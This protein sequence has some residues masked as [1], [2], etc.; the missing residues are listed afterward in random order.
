M[1]QHKQHEVVRRGS[2]KLTEWVKRTALPEDVSQEIC[3]PVT[4]TINGVPKVWSFDLGLTAEQRTKYVDALKR[5]PIGKGK[6]TLGLK[7]ASRV[8]GYRPRLILRNDYCSPAS[9][10]KDDPKAHALMVELGARAAE[11]YAQACPEKYAAHLALTKEKVLPEYHIGGS[12]F[13]SGIIN[14]DNALKYH[15]DAGN[16]K[17]V[18]SA[19]VCFRE[20]ATGGGSQHSGVRPAPGDFR[21]QRDNLRR[22]IN[23]AWGHSYH[24]DAP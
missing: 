22:T 6:R 9:L 11:L 15:F 21:Q 17:G 19:M 1:T 23:F 2:L 12:P 18:A 16:F 5:V 14:R 4:L 20:E 10:A 3:G 13:T 7:S 24:Q 8:I